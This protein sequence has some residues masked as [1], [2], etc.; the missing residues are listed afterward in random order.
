MKVVAHCAG[1][2]SATSTPMIAACRAAGTHY[3]DDITPRRSRCS[4]R[5]TPAT[6]RPA[7]P[8]SWSARAEASM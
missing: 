7:R 1:P 6:P 2:F 3:V 8:A 5:P 4:S